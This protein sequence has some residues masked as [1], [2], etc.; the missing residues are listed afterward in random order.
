MYTDQEKNRIAW[1]EYSKFNVGKEVDIESSDGKREKTIGYVSEIFGQPPEEDMVTSLE[2]FVARFEGDMSGLNGYIVTDKKITHETRPEDVHEVTIL[3]EGSEAHFDKKFM[4]AMDDWVLTDAPTALQISMAKRL[5]IKT[6]KTSQLDA[7]SKEVKAAM[8]RYPNARFKFYAHSLG[9]LN[10][11]ASLASLEDK[12]LDRVDAAYI[13]EAPN[14]YPLLSDEEKKQV[15]KIKYKIYNFVDKRDLV[16]WE[17]YDEGNEGVVGTLVRIDS[18]DAG[19]LG[20]QHMWGGYDYKAGYL[21]VK[22]ES[23]DDYRLA[24]VKQAK[25]Q[26]QLKKKTL[27]S[28]KKRGLSESDLIFMDTTQATG[29]VE[30]LKEFALIASDYILAVCDF[31]IADVR[32]SWDSLLASCYSSV[33]GTRC[34]MSDIVNALSQ[35]GVTMETIEG[36]RITE[37]EKIKKDTLKIKES[38]FS[39][40]TDIA[41]GIATVA[42]TDIALASQLQLQW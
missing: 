39:L 40:S 33:S 30:S 16:T 15:D 23:L 28:W 10:I 19:N 22:E 31:G 24:R 26:L 35:I 27:E 11:Q 18:K 17:H 38:I 3:F 4:E 12:Y 5:G 42:G 1:K 34:T 7:A 29:I 13:Y 41:K 14:L 36:N 37:L 20:K 21:N 2:D 32:G 9:G 8:K 25:E 6:G